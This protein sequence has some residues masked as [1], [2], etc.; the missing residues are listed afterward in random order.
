VLLEA[1]IVGR[2]GRL[3]QAV[4]SAS[5]ADQP[6]LKVELTLSGDP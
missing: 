5:V 3:I 1:H 2:I 4:A 6:V